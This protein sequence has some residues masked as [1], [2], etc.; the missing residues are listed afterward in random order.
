VSYTYPPRRAGLGRRFADIVG[1]AE[2]AA[3]APD[4]SRLLGGPAVIPL[5]VVPFAMLVADRTGRVR[6]ANERWSALSGIDA[7]ASVGSGWLAAMREDERASLQAA[8]DQVAAGG[9]ARRLRYRW[10]DG[11]GGAAGISLASVARAGDILVGIAVEPRAT[12]PDPLGQEVVRLLHSVNSLMDTLDRVVAHLQP[13][14]PEALV[15]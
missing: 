3:A 15:G 6:A 5:D 2:P 4:S 1:P 9:P 11:R 14:V 8:V 10:H 13:S 12:R 7:D